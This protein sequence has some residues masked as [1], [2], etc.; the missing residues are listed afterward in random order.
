[1]LLSGAV[2]GTPAAQLTANASTSAVITNAGVRSGSGGGGGGG[3]DKFGAPLSPGGTPQE[4]YEWEEGR[5][6]RKKH[7]SSAAAAV[8]GQLNTG[9]TE[10]STDGKALGVFGEDPDELFGG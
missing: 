2:N 7:S 4:E 3:S 8:R 9:E 6:R 1:M 5:F 10:Y